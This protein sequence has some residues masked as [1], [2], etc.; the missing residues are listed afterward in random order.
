MYEDAFSEPALR[1]SPEEVLSHVYFASLLRHLTEE[2]Q[3]VVL[4]RFVGGLSHREI[5][6][7]IESNPDAVKMKV[8][9][10]VQR[11]REILRNEGI[12]NLGSA[13]VGRRERE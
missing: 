3:E 9:R 7:V 8:Y 4:L 12:N 1:P 2:Q 6:E 5:A 11:L 13:Q 10:A